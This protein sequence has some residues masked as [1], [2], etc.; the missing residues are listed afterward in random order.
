MSDQTVEMA[1]FG[2][3]KDDQIYA[4]MEQQKKY[5]ENLLLTLNE[6]VSLLKENFIFQEYY[7]VKQSLIAWKN[8]VSDRIENRKK[9]KCK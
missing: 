8:N 2:I 3:T 7:C 1:H 9:I 5:D 6:I 4:L